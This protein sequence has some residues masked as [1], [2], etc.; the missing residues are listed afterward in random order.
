MK[1]ISPIRTFLYVILVLSCVETEVAFAQTKNNPGHG[2]AITKA[3][4]A[5][6][7]DGV[8]E[9]ED[10]KLAAVATNFFLNYPVDSLPPAFQT[11]VRFYTGHRTGR[12]LWACNF[13]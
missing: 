1:Q 5:I 3:K 13:K 9:E 2:L 10:W 12:K 4:R 6:V 11:E 7:A 8:L